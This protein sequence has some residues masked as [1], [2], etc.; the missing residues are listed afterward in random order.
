MNNSARVCVFVRLKPLHNSRYTCRVLC[1][2]PVP[3]QLD[4]WVLT[5]E[6]STQHWSWWVPH[7]LHTWLR[8]QK[9]FGSW[10]GLCT[11]RTGVGVTCV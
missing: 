11:S 6:R 3:A 10:T 9:A 2:R 8:G 4:R 5:G 7:C 1:S